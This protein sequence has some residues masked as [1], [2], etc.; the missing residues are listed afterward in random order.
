MILV[1]KLE[2]EGNAGLCRLNLKSCRLDFVIIEPRPHIAHCSSEFLS[3][4]FHADVKGRTERHLRLRSQ[5]VAQFERTAG[6][7]LPGDEH[8]PAKFSP[9]GG[10]LWAYPTPYSAG[11]RCGQ[12]RNLPRSARAWRPTVARRRV[13][14]TDR[15]RGQLRPLRSAPPCERAYGVLQ[16]IVLG[17]RHH[18]VTT[19]DHHD[20]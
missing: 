20:R 15:L 5:K 13:D 14:R 18:F 7:D 10:N 3:R 8:R 2:I 16:A 11:V 12:P 9:S 1:W 17:E 6:R 19:G 4:S